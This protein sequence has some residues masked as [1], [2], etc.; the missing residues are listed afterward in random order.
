MAMKNCSSL[1]T[2]G[3]S[4]DTRPAEPRPRSGCCLGR[5]V[6]H[7][8][9]HQPASLRRTSRKY[10]GDDSDWGLQPLKVVPQLKNHV[11]RLGHVGHKDGLLPATTSREAAK[12]SAL[13]ML[14]K[15]YESICGR[16]LDLPLCKF[17]FSCFFCRN[18]SIKL[19]DDKVRDYSMDGYGTGGCLRDGMSLRV[20][21]ALELDSVRELW[22]NWLVVSGSKSGGGRGL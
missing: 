20:R 6:I 14:P 5:R 11:K 17:N 13:P 2:P 4:T 18:V 19:I 15:R 7:S 22:I 1:G 8:R 3:L 16:P 12:L 21:R 10:N 9:G